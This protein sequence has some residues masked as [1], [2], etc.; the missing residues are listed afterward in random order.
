MS[1]SPKYCYVNGC[2]YTYGDT[3]S[4]PANENFSVKFSKNLNFVDCV[5]DSQCG[6]SNHRIVRTTLNFLLNNKDC[7]DDLLVIIGWTC[8][9]RIELWSDYSHEWLW[10]NQY[11][12]SEYSEK[13]HKARLYYQNIWNEVNAY[14]DYF[15]N[16]ITLQSFL[17]LHNIKYYMFRSFAFQNPLTNKFYGN[18]ADFE[19]YYQHVKNKF[20][21]EDY[22]DSVDKILFPSFVHFE[23]TWHG[24]IKDHIRT[25]GRT[26]AQHYPVH[27]NKEEH[28]IF[29]DYL[30]EEIKQIYKIF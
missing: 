5:N 4:D 20:I 25:D 3:L 29:A 10:I 15:L 9:H 16:V 26:F 18:D 28:E 22:I 8:P 12:Q 19:Q 7:W 11:R 17:K 21:P 27:P 6:G 2:S 23:K 24:V 30:T 13:G 1:N 14:T